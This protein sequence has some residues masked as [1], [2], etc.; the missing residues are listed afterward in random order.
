[1][2]K[3]IVLFFALASYI[4]AYSQYCSGREATISI[5]NLKFENPNSFSF[6]VEI[7]NSGTTSLAFSALGGSIIGLPNGV[8]GTFES[9]SHPRELNNILGDIITKFDSKINDF[10]HPVMRWTSIPSFQ[11]GVKLST[12]RSKY[13]RFRFTRLGGTEIPK[14]LELKF[15]ELGI[16]RAQAIAYC[17]DN[18]NSIALTVDNLGLKT[19][20]IKYFNGVSR[21]IN[22]SPSLIS[23]VPNPTADIVNVDI[24][25]LLS[26]DGDLDMD[27]I[28]IDGK[29]VISRQ[30]DKTNTIHAISVAHLA[31]ASYI[32]RVS[33]NGQVHSKKLVK[34]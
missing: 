11:K 6:D 31:P 25:S 3:L 20:G 16:S 4:H 33:Q 26:R 27:I 28:D 1:M 13:T 2:K 23:V 12:E 18:S 32:V 5:T 15:K 14:D 34:I 19:E 30:L 17:N 7:R 9:I 24:S 21:V 8:E 22:S 29:I 10:S